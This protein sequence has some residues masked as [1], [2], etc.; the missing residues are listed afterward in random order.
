MVSFACWTTDSLALKKRVEGVLEQ[1]LMFKVI[2]CTFQSFQQTPQSTP[3]FKH[4]L[5]KEIAFE[6]PNLYSGIT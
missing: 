2:K 3:F 4:F 6:L 1:N 5:L